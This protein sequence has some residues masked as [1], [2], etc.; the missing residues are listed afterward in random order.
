[1]GAGPMETLA[2]EPTAR[3]EPRS[4]PD[5]PGWLGFEDAFFMAALMGVEGLAA[6]ADVARYPRRPSE[7]G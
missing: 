1:M 7:M 4:G 3:A 5:V 2:I 6:F